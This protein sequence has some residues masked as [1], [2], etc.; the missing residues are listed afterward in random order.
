MLQID[1]MSEQ[2]PVSDACRGAHARAVAF[3]DAVSGDETPLLHAINALM[4]LLDLLQLRGGALTSSELDRLASASHS[5]LPHLIASIDGQLP[6]DRV[7][8]AM[9]QTI[10]AVRACCGGP[11]ERHWISAEHAEEMGH[12]MHWLR[13]AL[14]ELHQRRQIAERGDTIFR[15][16]LARRAF[17]QA[18]PDGLTH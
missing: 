11:E 16:V 10:L 1:A 8:V 15:H 7:A 12:H 14:E 5:A 6:V 13:A 9:G 4:A 3:F 2:S 18:V 17:D